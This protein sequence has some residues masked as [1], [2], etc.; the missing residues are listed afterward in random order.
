MIHYSIWF[1]LREGA[2]EPDLI[3]RIDAFLIDQENREAI[4][5]FTLLRN[6]ASEGQTQLGPFRRLL[7]S[8]LRSSSPPPFGRLLA[9]VSIVVCTARW[10]S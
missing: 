5:G 8:G 7:R 9:R 2:S 4:E 1:W 10:R 3:R 6:R